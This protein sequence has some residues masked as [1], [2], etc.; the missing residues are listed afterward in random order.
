[1]LEIHSGNA[2]GYIDT[3][4]GVWV[5]TVWED[6]PNVLSGPAAALSADGRYLFFPS[7]PPGVSP[8]ADD[9]IMVYDRTERTVQ[10]LAIGDLGSISKIVV[11]AKE[12]T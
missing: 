7:T 9:A 2:D 4:S 5:P 3:E 8:P 10:P 11:L 12:P 6:H 1:M